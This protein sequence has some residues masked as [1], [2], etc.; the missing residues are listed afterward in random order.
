[1]KLYRATLEK[2]IVFSESIIITAEN[3]NSIDFDKVIYCEISP[4][5]AMGNEGGILIYVLNSEDNLITYETNVFKDQE[6]FDSAVERIEQNLDLFVNYSGGF[7]N[8]VYIKKNIEFE[9]D[10]K[11]KCFWYHSK[12][13][14]LRIDTSVEGVFLIVSA[15]MT[16]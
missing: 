7:G 15:E 16:G 3:L 14:K 5:G 4:K 10:E 11:Y 1:M 13:T 8:Y 2:P 12:N 6:S 9:I